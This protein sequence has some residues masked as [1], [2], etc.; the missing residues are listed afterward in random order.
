MARQPGHR[1]L[2][3]RKPGPVLIELNR[4][5][6]DRHHPLERDLPA[7][8]HNSEPAPPDLLS[9]RESG[10]S[11]CGG[12]ATG[13]ITPCRARFRLRSSQVAIHHIPRHL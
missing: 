3:P 8:V 11:Q 9:I 12:D 2:L 1:L 7:A 6:L 4:E 13:H 5:H 10:S